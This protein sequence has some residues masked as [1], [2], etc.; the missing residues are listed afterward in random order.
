MTARIKPFV[1]ARSADFTRFMEAHRLSSYDMAALFG[2]SRTTVDKYR[3]AP[4][5]TILP[6]TLSMAMALIDAA[7]S[8]YLNKK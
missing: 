3:H 5:K 7:P 4:P 2:L 1:R 6:V 8:H